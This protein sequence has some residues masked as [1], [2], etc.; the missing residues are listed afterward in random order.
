[1]DKSWMRESNRC[2]ERFQKGVKEFMGMVIKS[3]DARDMTKCP[4]CD[5]LLQ[6]HYYQLFYI[7]RMHTFLY[8]VQLLHIYHKFRNES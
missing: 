4:C 6:L 8:N 5:L 3:M 2:S 7:L 1:M